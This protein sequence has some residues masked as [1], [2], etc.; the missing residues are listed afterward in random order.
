MLRRPKRKFWFFLLAFPLFFFLMGYL[1]MLLW[2]YSLVQITP[3]QRLNL[4]QAMALLLLC[5]ILFGGFRFGGTPRGG[6]V[7]HPKAPHWRE[8]WMNMSEEERERFKAE[9]KKRC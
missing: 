1:V 7:S 2:N 6:G 3:L 4:W 9:W 8:K 5:R